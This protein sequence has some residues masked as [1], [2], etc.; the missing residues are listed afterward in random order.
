MTDEAR[1]FWVVEPGRGEIRREPLR[2]PSDD[3]VVVHALYSGISRGTEALVFQGRVPESEWDRMRAPFQEGDFSGPLKY[4]YANV[5]RVECGPE[6]LKG[7]TVFVLYPHQTRYVVPASS[8]HVVPGDIPPARAV[9]AANLETALNGVWDARPHVGD[10]VVVIGAGTVG[11]L[12]AWLAARI[13]GCEVQLVDVNPQRAGIAERLGVSFAQPGDAAREADVV[14]H[15]S[16]S[17]EGLQL[18]LD[19]AGLEATILEMSWFGNRSVPLQLGGAFH[20]KRLTI[21]SSQVGRVAPSQRARW[22]LRRRM[23]LALTLL[24]D[25]SLDALIT[26]ESPFD[27]LPHVMAALA[28]PP[29]DVLCHRIKYAS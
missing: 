15:A 12:V 11:C 3:E 26:G 21:K 16:G 6:N 19:I 23:A 22:D 18:A 17:P 24:A 29:G 2:P 8:V 7:K 27:E 20:S 25:E 1:A 9:L 28:D 13:H 5:G 10:R 14:I 4:G